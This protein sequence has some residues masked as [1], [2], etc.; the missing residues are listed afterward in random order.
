MGQNSHYH[1]LTLDQHTLQTLK[2]AVVI[3]SHASS[4]KQCVMRLTAIC[5]DLG[6]MF[7]SIQRPTESGS[8]SYHGHEVH[9]AVLAELFLKHLG[10]EQYA[11]QVKPLVRHHMRPHDLVKNASTRAIR[12]FLVDLEQDGVHWADL[13][14]QAEADVKGKT[15]DYVP[16]WD[17]YLDSLNA[18]R[19]KIQA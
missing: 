3:N 12:R 4:D 10:L 2:H 13:L 1:V 9:S 18:L 5:H 7:Q 17:A 14:N 19:S 6:K 8:V 11:S 15:V 16:A